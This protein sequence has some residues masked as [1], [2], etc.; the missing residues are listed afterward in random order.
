MKEN[1]HITAPEI[2]WRTEGLRTTSVELKLV[3]SYSDLNVE[4]T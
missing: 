4:N 1:K 2:H 3:R